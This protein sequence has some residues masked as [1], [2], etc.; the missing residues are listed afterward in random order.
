MKIHRSNSK[1]SRSFLSPMFTRS[2]GTSIEKMAS[3]MDLN[4]IPRWTFDRY[5]FYKC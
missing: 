1:Y 4:L 5:Y 2:R 3:R